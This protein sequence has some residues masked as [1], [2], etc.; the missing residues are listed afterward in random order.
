MQELEQEEKTYVAEISD[1]DFNLCL[2]P[3]L[4]NQGSFHFVWLLWVG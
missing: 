4:D 3:R 1:V 2:S